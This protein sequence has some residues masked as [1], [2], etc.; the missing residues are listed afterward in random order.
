MTSKGSI[1]FSLEISVRKSFLPVVSAHSA[2]TSLTP[3]LSVHQGSWSVRVSAPRTAV[4]R[5]GVIGVF[6]RMWR[7]QF[8]EVSLYKFLHLAKDYAEFKRRII[9]KCVLSSCLITG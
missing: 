5:L 4:S 9:Q 2:L 6:F 7:M 8:S 3:V 1:F